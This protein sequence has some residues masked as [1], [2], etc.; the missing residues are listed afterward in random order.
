MDWDERHALWK[1]LRSL[2]PARVVELGR[3]KD[4]MR[5]AHQLGDARLSSQWAQRAAQIAIRAGAGRA[6]ELEIERAKLA[7]RA[8]RIVACRH[9]AGQALRANPHSAD[10]NEEAAEILLHWGDRRRAAACLSRP[11]ASDN[12]PPNPKLLLR[13]ALVA[14]ESGQPEEALALAEQILKV[15]RISASQLVAVGEVFLDL[16]DTS[17]AERCFH[18]A[19]DADPRETHAHLALA[20]VHL[21]RGHTDAAREHAHKAGEIAPTDVQVRLAQALV[22]LAQPSFSTADLAIFDAAVEALPRQAELRGLRAQARRRCGDTRGAAEDL[23]TAKHSGTEAQNFIFDLELTAIGRQFE[24]SPNVEALTAWARSRQTPPALEPEK[25]TFV[26]ELRRLGE[27]SLAK[28]LWTLP[29]AALERIGDRMH[30]RFQ[31]EEGELA[32]P[33]SLRLRLMARLCPDEL[34]RS[35]C[36]NRSARPTY[37]DPRTEQLLPLRLRRS[38]RHVAKTTQWS[39][40]YTTPDEVLNAFGEIERAYPRSHHPYAYRGEVLLWL[41]RYDEAAVDFE[42]GLRINP[43]ARWIHIGMGAVHGFQGRTQ[44]ALASFQ[45]SVDVAPDFVGPTLY[46]YRGEAL[47]VAGQTREALRDLQIACR[48]NPSRIGAWVHLCL[49]A[50]E[51]GDESEQNRAWNELVTRAPFLLSDAAEEHF[52][53]SIYEVERGSERRSLLEY[54]LGMMRG[55]RSSSCVTYFTRTNELRVV[56][57]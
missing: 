51:S 16:F 35:T 34:L 56:N 48:D 53:R 47:R 23:V 8:G 32:M 50:Q 49:L 55:N 2:D 22:C 26:R 15:P 40:L 39:L 13:Q 33:E 4:A 24:G 36:G 7:Q 42:K 1:A 17:A 57:L 31:V 46:A 52:S 25:N 43:K 45:R 3:A 19:L 44:A 5:L 41:G 12:A 14:V 54:V 9:H 6:A 21:M 28:M 27:T 10:I 38:S 37:V 20:R 18:R 30:D 11:H 29:D